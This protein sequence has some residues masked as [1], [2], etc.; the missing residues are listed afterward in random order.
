M[1]RDR[2][3]EG[4]LFALL[5]SLNTRNISFTAVVIQILFLVSAIIGTAVQLT[6]SII[7]NLT[8]V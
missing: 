1:H 3:C 8:S 4:R 6:Y 2:G 5:R 7:T